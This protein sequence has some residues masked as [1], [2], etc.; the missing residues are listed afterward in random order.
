ML[1]LLRVWFVVYSDSEGLRHSI[2]GMLRELQPAA[3]YEGHKRVDRNSRAWVGIKAAPQ[4][5]CYSPGK[6][7]RQGVHH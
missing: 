4:A 3:S 2:L 6:G 5:F 7:A 1:T